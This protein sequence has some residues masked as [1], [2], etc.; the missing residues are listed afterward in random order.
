MKVLLHPATTALGLSVLWFL[1]LLGPLIDP[2]RSFVY[3][4]SGSKTSVFVAVLFV[5]GLLWLLLTGLLFLLQGRVR[6]RVMVWSCLILAIPLIL[7]KDTA[8]VME[9]SI[10]HWL[11]VSWFVGSLVFSVVLTIFWR[12]S[13]QTRFDR[14]QRFAATLLGFAAISSVLILGQLFW[15]FQQTLGTKPPAPLHAKSLER[16]DAHA[17][18]KPRVIWILLDELSYQQVYEQRYAGLNLPAFDRLAEQ[19]TIFTH[20]VPAGIK[21]EKVLPSLMT[22]LPVDRIH[23]SADGHEL[24][25]HNAQSGRWQAFDP[26]DTIFQDA[27]NDGYSTAVAGWYNPYCWL[28]PQVLDQCFWTSHQPI[29][30]NMMIDATVTENTAAPLLHMVSSVSS[31]FRRSSSLSEETN[32]AKVHIRDYLDLLAAGDAR[33]N[34]SSATFL[35]LHM[36]IPHPDGIYNRRTGVLAAGNPSY[37]NNLALADEYLRHVMS[38]LQQRREWD[39]SA[40]IVMGDH[41]WRTRLIWAHSPDWTAEEDAASH[42]G[43]FDDRPG[44]IVKLPGQHQAARI[45]EPFAAIRTRALLRNILNGRILTS[46]DLAIWARDKYAQ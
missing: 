29:P 25:F 17:A 14:V 11:N 39:S 18:P 46:T 22:G 7:L 3:H 27:L 4:E 31:N 32:E 23:P 19:A 33:L 21:T 9:R 40:V 34:D 2:A 45:D 5:V 16:V 13:F 41:S 44:Y 24:S 15:C 43:Q 20:V 36:P 6:P 1:Q 38:L 37:L 26:H 10:P 35:F 12:T 42:G 28:L 30:G 8:F